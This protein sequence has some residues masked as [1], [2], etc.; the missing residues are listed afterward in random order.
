[1]A[2]TGSS[3]LDGGKSRTR[4]TA[5]RGVE[6]ALGSS[7]S[8]F[9]TC[10]SAAAGA[11]VTYCW[12]TREPAALISLKWIADELS[13][14]EYSLIGMDTKPKLSDSEAIER[15]AMISVLRPCLGTLAGT[16]RTRR[17]HAT[18]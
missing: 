18:R 9:A 15:A 11:S 5:P 12:R 6:A 14:A 3:P 13:V 17:T 8:S 10:S 1:M 2:V 7:G 16:V 4:D